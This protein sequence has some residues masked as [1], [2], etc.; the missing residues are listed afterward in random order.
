MTSSR[1][2]GSTRLQVAVVIVGLVAAQFYVRPWFGENRG[3]PDFLL[4][5]LLLF[6]IRSR[7]GVAAVAGFLVG[8]ATDALTPARFGA[9]A[10]SHTIV[11]YL[12]AWGRAVFF[13]DN[14]LVNA[15]LF[16]VGVWL[17]TLIQLLV[18]GEAL[19]QMVSI[20]AVWAPLQAVT[21][22]IVGVLVVL[23][24]R[25]WLAIRLDE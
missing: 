17:R 12:A 11:G 25:D 19:S 6:S 9:G 2:G 7:P 13:P 8:L 18:S 22:A 14:L 5:A 4:L 15:G 1:R 23:L 20:L 16:A 21:T 10:L 24:F 3:A